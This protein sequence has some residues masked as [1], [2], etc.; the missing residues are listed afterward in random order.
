[1]FCLV[2]VNGVWLSGELLGLFILA[3]YNLQPLLGKTSI[4]PAD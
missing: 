2:P 4:I 1:M 3:F